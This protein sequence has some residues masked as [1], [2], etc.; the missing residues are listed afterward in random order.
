MADP[1]EV[2]HGEEERVPGLS[3][4]GAG[5]GRRVQWSGAVVASPG[6]DE[7]TKNLIY[8]AM[9]AAT[10]DP[11]AVFAHVPMAKKLGATRDEIKTTIL[12]TLSVVGLKAVNACLA[13]GLAIYDGAGSVP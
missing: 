4:R 6:L 5:R 13:D 2:G 9:K 7:K 11:G 12:L 8:I 10:G 1:L 3:G